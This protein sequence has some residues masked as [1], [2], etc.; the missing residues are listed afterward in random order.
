MKRTTSFVALLVVL[1]ASSAFAEIKLPPLFADHMVLQRGMAVPVWG[2]VSPNQEVT[3]EVAGR[4]ARATADAQGNFVAKLPELSSGGNAVT[5]TIDAGGEKLVLNDV[6]IGDVWLASG[7][8]NMEWT[9]THLARGDASGAKLKELTS[10]GADLPNVRLFTFP[11][12]TLAEPTKVVRGEWK[13]S[14]P[15]ALV[16]FSAVAFYFGRG[17]HEAQK[18]PVGLIS[19]AWGG[20]PVE[21]FMSDEA[22]RSD[23]AFQPLL[24]RKEQ[25]GKDHPRAMAAYEKK[26]AEWEK[27]AAANASARPATKPQEPLGAA[28]SNLASN[29][30]NGMV[31]P[32][33]PYAIKGAIWYQGES[34]AGRAEQYRALFPAMITDWRKQ[35]GQGDFPFI[36]VQLANFKERKADP[37]DSDWAELREA[38]SMALKLPNTGQAVIIDIG[39]AN[40]IHP[41]NKHDVGKRLA[42]AAERIA[43]GRND[44]VHSG[45]AFA[46]MKVEGNQARLK[47]QHADGLTAKDGNLKGFAIAG[48]DKKFVWADAKID[49]DVVIVSAKGVEK[50]IAVRYAWA[51]N[52]E[53]NLHNGAGL[54]ASPFRTDD[55]PMITEGKQ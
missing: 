48:E 47:F 29:I 21:S 27:N 50:P 19:N 14:S 38:Q 4:T 16:N 15:E 36:W 12:T 22:M 31:N 26:F 54:P 55:F 7:Q 43:Y 20:K 33:V 5:M 30:F 6:L 10:A 51:D 3:I 44:V 37:A 52:P 45:P 46:S 8:S 40:D 24:D 49:G 11:K 34:N 41:K 18:V 13:V 53:C 42:L 28:D 1:V 17:I 9:F 39:E 25:A 32:V 23:R 2:T 35:W